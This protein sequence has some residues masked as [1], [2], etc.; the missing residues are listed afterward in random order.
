L[1]SVSEPASAEEAAAVFAEAAQA[2]SRVSIGREGGDVVLS[3][4]GLSR[5]VQH[6]QGDLTATVEAGLRLSTLQAELAGAGQRLSL[7]PPGDPTLGALVATNA[8]GPLRHRYGAPRDLLLGV[9]VVL[10]DGTVASSGGTV[11]KNVAGYDLGKL[12]CGSRGRLGLLVRLSVRLHPVPAASRTVVVDVGRPEEAARLWQALQRSTLVPSAVDVLWPRS[13][14]VLFEGGERAV[15][16]QVES[17]AGLLGGQ[18]DGGE[19]WAEARER[20]DS[21]PGVRSFAPGELAGVLGE[22]GE[23]IVRP[24]PGVAHVGAQAAPADDPVLAALRERIRAALD[25]KGVLA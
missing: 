18:E 16:A 15:A 17:A 24:G 21:L 3:T 7:D 22:I 4:A 6:A 20:Q 19:V 25:P 13:V 10:A 1:P 23:G 5:L 14:A 11:V 9:T 12:L 8:A 2:G